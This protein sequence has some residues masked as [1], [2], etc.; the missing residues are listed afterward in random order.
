MF[1]SVNEEAVYARNN[2]YRPIGTRGKIRGGFRGVK[3][4]QRARCTAGRVQ[5]RLYGRK[6]TRGNLALNSN[7][8]TNEKEVID[9]ENERKVVK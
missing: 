6:A 1:K 2:F 3:S 7:N 8:N 9:K 4:F 5:V